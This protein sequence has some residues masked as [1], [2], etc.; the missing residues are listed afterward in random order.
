MPVGVI[1][2]KYASI[3]YFAKVLLLQ[4]LTLSSEVLITGS[5]CKTNV[6][7]SKY[8]PSLPQLLLLSTGY[9]SGQPGSPDL[10]DLF[11]ALCVPSAPHCQGS[12]RNKFLALCNSAQQQLKHWCIII[13]IFIRN[14]KHSL[15]PTST[16]KIKAIPAKTM[17]LMH[18]VMSPIF[19]WNCTR[20]HQVEW[21]KTVLGSNI[22]SDPSSKTLPR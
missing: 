11:P 15:I 1:I 8:P 10:P 7:H 21:E 12:K 2:T 16:K 20:L 17:A 19:T 5:S 14:P 18:A 6:S 4:T 22:Y 13:T 3:K 9:L